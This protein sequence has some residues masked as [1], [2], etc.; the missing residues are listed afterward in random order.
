[1]NLPF[2]KNSEGKKNFFI[3]LLI[4]PHKIGAILFEEI[5]DKLVIL[6]T[7]EVDVESDPGDLAQEEMLSA[8]DKV[9][10]YIEGS[11]PE[12]GSV[13]KVIFSLPWSWVVETKIKPEYL[14]K[15]KTVCKALDLQPIGYLTSIEA[16]VHFIEKQE[17]AP[18]SAI[19]IEVA[20]NKVISYLVRAGKILQVESGDIEENVISSTENLF[21]KIDSV[22]VLPAKMVLL[23]YEGAQDTQQDFLSHKWP[24][25][26]PFLHVPQVV[27]QER[28]FE[29]EATING[30][31]TQMELEVLSD[32]KTDEYEVDEEEK[33]EET[34]SA[35]F[36]FKKEG[37]EVA[38]QREILR[39]TT[40]KDEEGEG[41]ETKNESGKLSVESNVEE[42][43]IKYFK[44][45]DEDVEGGEG[46]LEEVGKTGSH[47]PI[48]LAGM[49]SPVR[50]FKIPNFSGIG[51]SGPF[52]FKL[53]AGVIGLIVIILGLTYLYNNF[54]LSS[55]IV[56]FADRRAIDKSTEVTFSKDPVSENSIKLDIISQEVEGDD[57]KN[58]TGEK[59]TG[60]KAKGSVTIYN[61]TEDKKTFPKGTI[62]V[63]PNNLEF[64]LLDEVNIASTSPF[65]TSL[66]TGSG[67]VQ[68]AKLGKEYNLPSNSNFTVKS[69]S[70]SQF[71]AKNSDAF[72][73]GSKKTSTVVS[74]KD[75]DSLLTSVMAELEGKAISSARSK[76][77]SKE[78]IFPKSLSSTIVDKKYSKKEGEEAGSVGITATIKYEVGKYSEDN[79]SNFVA[80][81]SKNEVPGTYVLLEGESKTEILNP[82]VDED[83][84]SVSATLKVNAVYSPKI[85]SEK[86]AEGMRGKSIDQAE[87]QI[88]GIAGVTD[89]VIS[90]SRQLPLF[91]VKLSGNAKNINIEIKNR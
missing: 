39:E 5:N 44:E 49:L 67:K 11:L 47:V 35:D 88:R 30:V 23:D 65:S 8:C 63:G 66:T 73:G 84:E 1:M 40:Q 19:F 15:L 55:K 83:G 91:P 13:E 87:Q 6:A 57:T 54:I 64:E 22:D 20:K 24:H 38:E 80:N 58:S 4:K 52:K 61:K 72:S 17:G 31:A 34:S 45:K 3:S 32:V 71:I 37:E 36:G 21:R 70:S 46:R 41:L 43:D 56:I 76:I 10:S 33:L 12:G 26:I 27:A 86:L 48:N 51:G 74:K 42:P 9:V 79:V 28:G 82:K 85:D 53:I 25:D 60:E 68:A 7:H 69:F 81:L 62:I 78:A 2:L 16:I 14:E 18:V 59:E 77:G 50:N 75:L 89:V 29:N 90:F